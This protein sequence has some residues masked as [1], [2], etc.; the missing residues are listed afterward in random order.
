MGLLAKKQLEKLKDE[1]EI[2][3]YEDALKLINKLAGIKIDFNPS[4][5][6]QL[7]RKVFTMVLYEVPKVKEQ[8]KGFYNRVN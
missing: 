7:T 3:L 6:E 8:V 5:E 1:E 2:V 4:Y